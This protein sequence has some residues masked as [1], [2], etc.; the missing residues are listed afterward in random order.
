MNIF[1]ILAALV[2]CVVPIY[3]IIKATILFNNDER[4]LITLADDM[5]FLTLEINFQ[6]FTIVVNLSVCIVLII[7]NKIAI[8]T[9]KSY[10][11]TTF[12]RETRN[13]TIIMYTFSVCYLIRTGYEA[14]ENVRNK[15]QIK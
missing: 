6:W 15:I 10:F 2:I 1:L 4:Q 5:K 9:L 11:A 14:Y 8:Q 12:K 7:T 13:S 3:F